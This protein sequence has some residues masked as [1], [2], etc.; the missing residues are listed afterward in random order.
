MDT[1]TRSAVTNDKMSTKKYILSIFGST[2]KNTVVIMRKYLNQ[3]LTAPL[4]NK[5]I[6]ELYCVCAYGRVCVQTYFFLSIQTYQYLLTNASY[7]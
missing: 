7:T 5:L 2:G 3:T 1:S 6:D 4:V